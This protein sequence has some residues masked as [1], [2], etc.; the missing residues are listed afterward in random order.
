MADIEYT[1][2]VEAAKV[3]AQTNFHTARAVIP[4]QQ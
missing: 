2:L 1:L 3:R 4:A